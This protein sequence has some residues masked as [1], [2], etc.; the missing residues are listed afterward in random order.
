MNFPIT[1]L[2]QPTPTTLRYIVRATV[3]VKRTLE[4]VIT[5]KVTA[6]GKAAPSLK[7]A[8]VE[9]VEIQPLYPAMDPDDLTDLQ[10]GRIVERL[11]TIEIGQAAQNDPA[12]LREKLRR[13]QVSFQAETDAAPL[14][15][16][17]KFVGEQFNGKVWG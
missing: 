5:E 12:L 10:A 11:C 8:A 6:L 17:F 16:Q 3:G 1:I 13:V 7:V 14:F 15:D 9:P 4:S 2:D